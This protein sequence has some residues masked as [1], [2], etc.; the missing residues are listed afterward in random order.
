MLRRDQTEFEPSC[1]WVLAGMTETLQR[2]RPVVLVEIH[3]DQREPVEAI[4]SEAGYRTRLLES[5]G[6]PHLLAVPDEG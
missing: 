2:H 1:R 5:A 3:G 6:M 4:L